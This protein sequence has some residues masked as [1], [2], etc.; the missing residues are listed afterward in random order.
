MHAHEEQQTGVRRPPLRRPSSPT[1]AR[2]A[3]AD[4]SASPAS[5]LSLQRSAG[6]AAVAR[7][8][9][10]QSGGLP[11]QRVTGA[12]VQRVRDDEYPDGTYGRRGKDRKYLEDEYDLDMGGSNFQVEHAHGYASTA[13]RAPRSRKSNTRHEGEILAY[14]E[15]LRAHRDHPGTGSSLKRRTTGLNSR[16]YRDRQEE[17]LLDDDPFRSLE[18][19]QLEYNP[20]PSFHAASGSREAEAADTSFRRSIKANPR[21]PIYDRN[22]ERRYTR[23]LRPGEQAQLDIGRTS[24]RERREVPHAE[25][26]RVLRE[27]YGGS[28]FDEYPTR[29]RGAADGDELTEFFDAPRERESSQRRALRKLAKTP[30]KRDYDLDLDDRDRGRSRSPYVDD[31]DYERPSR[32]DKSRGR[33]LSERDYY[34]EPP[35]R[36]K[37]SGRGLSDRDAY[38]SSRRYDA[39]EED[40]FQLSQPSEMPYSRRY[41][42]YDD[43]DDDYGSRRY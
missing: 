16:D 2:S 32:R 5:I 36:S 27:E 11:V 21:T 7:A 25:R 40:D 42:K 19:N 43:Y 22:G 28:R 13:R 33:G 41:D 37:S 17:Y 4:L 1:E 6:N 34:D 15:T 26:V 31:R 35:R 24:M 38:S 29:S 20:L 3:A 12:P 10:G 9:S 39:P 23:S 14:H 18:L 30:Y 8:L